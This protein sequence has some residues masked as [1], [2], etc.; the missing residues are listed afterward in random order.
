MVRD[1]REEMFS[2]MFDRDASSTIDYN[3]FKSLWQF[4]VQWEKVFRGFDE[5][6]S[7]TINK[8]E[9]RKALTS[10]GNEKKHIQRKESMDSCISIDKI[11]PLLPQD[12]TIEGVCFV[13][14]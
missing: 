12:E 2:G 11:F 10:F 3:E 14:Q 7:G 13:F 6:Q 5:D 4:V 8:D 9:F 1:A